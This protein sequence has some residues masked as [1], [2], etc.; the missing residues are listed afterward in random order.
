MKRFISL[1]FISL[2]MLNSN[3]LL[4]QEM[5]SKKI[6]ANEACVKTLLMG[7]NSENC[8]VKNGCAFMFGELCCDKGVIPLLKILHSDQKEEARIMAALSLYKIG[9]SR[10]I[11]AIKQ[12]I[13][14]D[15]S[16][17]VSRLCEKFY[18]AFLF[19]KKNNLKT[20]VALN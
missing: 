9:D 20:D 18:K 8:G 10:G 12:A 17:R 1:F 15:N 16:K 14:F 2:L 7:L 19:G 13:R 4:P 6:T 3:I 5:N 11:F